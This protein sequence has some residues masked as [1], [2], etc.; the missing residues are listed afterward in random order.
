MVDDADELYDEE[1]EEYGD[2]EERWRLREG[3]AG[4]G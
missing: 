2:C 4:H 1:Y 3:P